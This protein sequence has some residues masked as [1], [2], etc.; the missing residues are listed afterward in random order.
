MNCENICVCSSWEYSL[1]LERSRDLRKPGG[2]GRVTK[3]LPQFSICHSP[4]PPPP[5]TQLLALA[6]QDLW[7]SKSHFSHRPSPT[8]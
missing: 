3:G 1:W 2:S 4:P 6:A 7:L 5:C 8:P